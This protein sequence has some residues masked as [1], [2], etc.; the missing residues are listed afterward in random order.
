MNIE[1]C[2]KCQENEYIKCLVITSGPNNV[3]YDWINIPQFCSVIYH[4]ADYITIICDKEFHKHTRINSFEEI[5]PDEW[6][7]CKC[8]AEQL[9]DFLNKEVKV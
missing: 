4:E 1:I 6:K 3:N 9:V 8:Y 2:K 7:E 5:N